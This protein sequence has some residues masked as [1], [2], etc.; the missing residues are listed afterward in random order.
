MATICSILI[1][2]FVLFIWRGEAYRERIIL[3]E[4]LGCRAFGTFGTT[5]DHLRVF[6]VYVIA[7]PCFPSNIGGL[8][9]QASHCN[10]SWMVVR[11]W[12]GDIFFKVL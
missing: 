2:H 3:R 11:I 1:F 4:S 12:P 9:P 10:V 7:F 8:Q 5:F 6:D